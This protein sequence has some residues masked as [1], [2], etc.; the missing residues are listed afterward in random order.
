MSTNMFFRRCVQ[1]IAVLALLLTA[2]FNLQAQAPRFRVIAFYHGTYDPA[3]ISFVREANQ[4]FP[5]I[6]AQYNFSYEATTNWDNLNASFLSQYQVVLFLDDLP[7]S[8]SQR[9]AFQQYMQNGGAWMGFHVSAFTQN[10]G[11]WSWYHN[12][13]LGTGNFSRNTWG[14]TSA[15][16]RVENRTHP[17][18]QR[19]PASFTS[20]V[21]EWY[22]WSN[23]LRNNSNISILA[24][25][26]PVSFPLGTDPNQSWYSGYYPIMWTNKNYKM[27]YANFGH[28]DMNYSNNT[29]KSS[30]FASEIQNRFIIDGL[31]WLGGAGPGPAPAIPVPGTVQAENYT[32]TSNTQTETTTDAGGGLNVGYIEAGSWL[33]YKVNVQT[34]GNYT[35]QYR[36]AS[37]SGGGSFQLRKDTA[38]LTSN[39]VAATGGWQN[40]ATIIDSAN[41]VAG[42]QTLR[43]HALSGGFNINWIQFS[44]ASNPTTAP[45]GQVITLQGPN[46]MFVS[47]ENGTKPMICN[48][49]APQ[50]WEQFTVVDAGAGKIALRS[51]DKYVSSENGTKPMNCNRLTVASYE[52]FDWVRN[53]DG[54]I[55][56]RGNNGMYV[57][58]ENGTTTMNCNRPAID[59]WEKFNFTVVSPAAAAS[60]ASAKISIA[61]AEATETAGPVYPNPAG[62]QLNYTL[63]GKYT[64][65]TVAVYDLTGR[66]HIRAVVKG[67]QSVYT[68]DVS[69]L[70]KGLY[71]L[72]VSSG[73]Y[74]QRTKVQKAE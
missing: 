72:D 59:G 31:L 8:A 27:L 39:N 35:I 63:P 5:Q 46:G 55:S 36:V 15:V 43:L 6:A 62:T 33:D 71:I 24:S 25:V 2:A 19:L 28:N 49:P 67:R 37:E 3:H 38:I 74:H 20:A 51:M 64:F 45:I 69:R 17:S 57:S 10:A 14:P 34:A 47:S 56:L 66:Q 41:L 54:T 68:L 42:E 7:A 70:P 12:T 40:W 52:R 65:H 29:P 9:T 44:S 30:T 18:T 4:W 13:F 53:S 1:T 58:S 22:S 61:P 21:S 48:R 16:L 23:D 11:G 73:N 60:T 26:D 50:G 32:A